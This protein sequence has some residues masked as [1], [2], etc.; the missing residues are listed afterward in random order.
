MNICIGNPDLSPDLIFIPTATP[1]TLS[2]FSRLFKI[3][4][5]QARNAIRDLTSLCLSS[6][7]LHCGVKHYTC[8]MHMHML[9]VHA[10]VHVH[11]CMY[12]RA[13][14]DPPR[15]IAYC[16]YSRTWTP[17]YIYIGRCRRSADEGAV[18]ANLPRTRDPHERRRGPRSARKLAAPSS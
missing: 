6:D 1:Y 3:S 2:I 13:A 4:K 9:H 14:S 15:Y 12:V 5:L 17:P 11:M 16:A 10:H 7:L 18:P 8:Y